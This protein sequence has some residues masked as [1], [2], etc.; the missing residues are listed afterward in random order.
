MRMWNKSLSSF[1]K[2]NEQVMVA[3]W[4]YDQEKYIYTLGYRS[5]DRWILEKERG[6]YQINAWMPLPNCPDNEPPSPEESIIADKTWE[7]SV[8]RIRK[9]VEDYLDMDSIKFEMLEAVSLGVREYFEN[10][11]DK[12]IKDLILSAIEMNL[13]ISDM[14]LSVRSKKKKKIK[15][16]K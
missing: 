7:F 16:E 2:D 12:E 9:V 8:E 13:E 11:S 10:Y 1:P 14:K 3:I 15:D 6:S 5:E 4:D